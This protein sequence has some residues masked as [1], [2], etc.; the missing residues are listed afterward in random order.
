MMRAL[1]PEVS[2]A[3]FAEIE[4]LLPD[5]PTHPLGCHRPRVSNRVCFKGLLLRIVTGAAW[6]TIEY[7]LDSQVSDTTLRARRDEWIDAGVFDRLAVNARAAYDKIIGLDTTH[8]VIDGSNHPA[9][10]GGPGTGIGPGQKGR[11][12]WKW[13]AAVDAAGIPLAVTTDGANRND[14]KMLRPTLDALAADP[15]PLKIGTLHLDRGFGYASAR[16]SHRLRHRCSRRHS[17]EPPRPG[18]SPPGRVRTPLGRRTHQLLVHQLRPAPPQHR[19][20]HRTPPRRHRPR[21]HPPRHRQAHRPPQP[22]HPTY[23]L[24]LLAP[25]DRGR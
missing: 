25:S 15:A 10:C 12:G 23:P 11:L 4:G 21:H 13:C 1:D 3:V 19:P 7:L 8:V 2:D 9:P 5:P 22:P 17:P 20:P 18:P 24:S 16:P 14:Y 6:E